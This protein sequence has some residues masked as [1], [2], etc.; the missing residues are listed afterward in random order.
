MWWKKNINKFF[1]RYKKDK[2]FI[3][4]NITI[5][6][7]ENFIVLCDK[8]TK[9]PVSALLT[10]FIRKKIVFGDNTDIIGFSKILIH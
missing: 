2:K 6:Y 3:G 9:E 7:K 4:F 1:H 10:R 5:P 8:I